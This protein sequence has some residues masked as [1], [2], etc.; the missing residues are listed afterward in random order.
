MKTERLKDML[1]MVAKKTE[2]K[3]KKK[4]EG[5][6]GAVPTYKTFLTLS[7][8]QILK[9]HYHPECNFH[10]TYS[11]PQVLIF[12]SQKI[13]YNCPSSTFCNLSQFEFS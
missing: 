6:K 3:R 1:E 8:V 11:C 9:P 13:L 12:L 2:W 7:L 10:I 4:I 5:K